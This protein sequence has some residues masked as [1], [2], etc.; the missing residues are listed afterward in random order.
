MR[1]LNDGQVEGVSAHHEPHDA[2]AKA[3]PFGATAPGISGLD[4]FLPLLLALVEQGDLSMMRAIE[5]A[6]VAPAAVI[7]SAPAS[8]AVGALADICVFDPSRSW[9]L[10]VDSM[11]SRGK[12]TPFLG[13]DMRGRA[14]VTLVGGR[15][16]YEL[17][18]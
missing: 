8:L 12:N 1:G 7:G 11:L 14:L 15:V 6:A 2:D 9:R 16:V 3:G 18:S 13:R 17:R 4:S 5:A 10:D